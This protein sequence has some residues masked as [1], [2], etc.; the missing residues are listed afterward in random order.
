M[1]KTT[2]KSH[3]FQPTLLALALL[4]PDVSMAIEELE[5]KKLS[6]KNA[7][8]T[9]AAAKAPDVVELQTIK[10]VAKANAD[11]DQDPNDPY[12]KTYTVTNSSTATKTDTPII[13][14][15][16]SIQVVPKSVMSDQKATTIKDAL[17]NISSVRPQSSL[18]LSNAFITRGFRNGRVFRNGL[19][20]NGLGIGEGTQFDSAN[21]ERIEVLKGPAAVLFGRIEPGGLVNLVT[22]KPRNEPYYSVEQRFG[23]YNFY[24]TEWDATD[25]VSKDKSVSYRFTGA[26]QNNKS[27]RDFNFNDRFLVNPSLTW[28]PSAATEMSLEVEALDE[29][30]QVD[31][32]LFAIGNRPAPIPISRSFIDPNDPVD[33]NSKVN[34]GFNLTH[35][36]NENWTLRNRFLASFIH[37]QNTSVKPAN[38]YTVEQ[39]FD[40][41]KGNRSYARNIFSQTSDNDTYSTNL[42]LTGKFKLAGVNHQTLVGMDYLRA[43]GTYK[44]YGNY[45][46]PV[47][48]LAIDIYNPTYGIDPSYYATA[49]ATPSDGGL[50]H[51]LFRDSWYGLYFQD[52]ITLWDKVHLL[53]GGRYDW[54]TTGIGVG[55]SASAAAAA[56]PS[57]NDEGFSPRV[58]VLYQAW[59]W[60]SL[61]GNWTTSF[62]A[63]NGI[64][65]TGTTINPE[66][67]EQF[68]AGVKTVL[69]DKRL[70]TTLAYYHLT[71]QNVLTRDFKSS[72]ALAVAAI[73]EARSQGIELDM[74]GQLTEEISVIGNYAFTDARITKD[75]SGLQGNRLNNVP[76]HSGS[77]WL[78]YDIHHYRPLNGLSFGMGVFAAG[79]RE[80]DN[81]NTFVLPGYARLDAFTSYAC[82]LGKSRLITQLNIRNLLDKV[83][84]E[85]TDP[86]QNAP[87]RVGIYPG[88]PLTAM[89]S[90]RLEF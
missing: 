78:K 19:V 80:G 48:G 58:G 10:V 15:P 74:T 45:Q 60:A 52:H 25:A 40:A 2:N 18:G 57:R 81:D 7:K 56:L 34:L 30:Y 46:D 38:A 22:K 8:K 3:F 47:T 37:D 72:D 13:E 42:D 87:P 59:E 16:V 20:A 31:R 61:Y 51:Y 71:K 63:N 43:V 11:S 29:Y 14:T 75:Y 50:N 66:I 76:E 28:R 68:E 5:E 33:N 86:F 23:S 26:Y 64:T 4:I 49:L 12:N 65:E 41:S 89:G 84:Y 85:S 90:V 35:A 27:F 88:A 39:F 77:L 44:I 82:Q 53:G 70:T 9:A 1:I 62:G 67:G 55:T 73:G 36:F 79:D 17:E 83:Y 32:G 69:F 21:L 6:A 24:R 54:A